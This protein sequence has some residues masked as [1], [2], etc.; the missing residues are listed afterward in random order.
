MAAAPI[1]SWTP[2]EPG[3]FAELAVRAL[4][5]CLDG[6]PPTRAGTTSGFVVGVRHDDGDGRLDLE[7]DADRATLALDPTLVPDHPWRDLWVL[8]IEHGEEALRLRVGDPP[9]AIA[10]RPDDPPGPLRRAGSFAKQTLG[11]V[12]PI[13]GV[14]DPVL[15]RDVAFHRYTRQTT[16]TAATA[17]G[18]P[19]WSQPTEPEHTPWWELDLGAG[20][21]LARVRVVVAR[22][23][24][25]ARVRVHAFGLH[26]PSGALPPRSLVSDTACEPSSE[27]PL[28]SVV[29]E[30]D[31][32]RRGVVARYLRI[33]LVAEEPV[34]LDVRA[35]ELLGSSLYE[36]TLLKTARTTFRLF[37]DRPLVLARGD[38]G[39][40]TATH[41]YGA[42]WTE[43][44][45]LARAL[46]A[47]LEPAPSRARVVLA[48]RG[49]PAWLIA[50][51]ACLLRAYV[52]V[53]IATDEPDERLAA[54]LTRVEPACV[55]AD[56]ADVERLRA[57]VPGA[58]LLVAVG[59]SVEGALEWT[60]LLAEGA[61]LAPIEDAARSEDDVHAIL[62]TSG[63]GGVPKGAMRTYA[64]F[65]DVI[66]SYSLGASPRHLSFQPLSHLSE[67]MFLPAVL[68]HGG[69]I[70][71]SRGPAHLL[72]ELRAFEPTGVGTVPRLFAS[73]HATYRRRLSA[74][75]AAAPDRTR[76]ELEGE[77]LAETRASLGRE[78]VAISI[79]SAPVSRELLAFVRHAFDDVWVSEGYG[80]TEVGTIA[81]DGR[82]AE[83]VEVELRP[84]GD[85]AD[86]AQEIWVRSP[87]VIAG[88]LGDGDA[89]TIDERGFFA[90]GDLGE[91]DA[92][93]RVRVVGRARNAI[94]L[95]AGEFVAVD[96]VEAV[97]G[98]AT[99]VDRVY[100]HAEPGGDGLAALVVPDAAA[101]ATALGVEPAP[102]EALCAHEDAPR[103]VLRALRAHGRAA[104]AAHELPSAA[105]L[106]AE[107]LRVEDGL[108]T[109]SGKLVRSA[110]ANRYGA[111][112]TALL[113]A[114]A[115]LEHDPLAAI[116]EDLEGRVR[117]IAASVLGRAVDLDE[118]LADAAIESLAAAELLAALS[119][120]LGREV[121]PAWLFG[122]AS[123]AALTERL[124]RFEHGFSAE[125]DEALRED[126]ARAPRVTPTS[127]L[128]A[129]RSRVLLTG[130]TGF[131][132]AH[133]VEAL[134]ARGLHV[135]ALVRAPDDAAAEARLRAALEGWRVPPVADAAL[136]AVAGDLDA[137]GLGLDEE[138]GFDAVVHAGARVSW[139]AGY[140]ALRGANVGGTIA[141][142]ERAA[143]RGAT[144]HHVSTISVAPPDADEDGFF[145]LDRVRASSTPY[146]LSKWVAESHVRRAAAAGLDVAVH[147]P[148]M[149]AA[150]STR[151][152]ANREDF[153]HRYLAAVI[154]LG[155]YVDDEVAILDMT[156]VDFVA[157]AIA[158]LVVAGPGAGRTHH[159]A[160][161]EGSLSYAALGRAV[162]AAGVTAA[163]VSH[164]RFLEALAA[165]EGSRLA[166]LASFIATPASLPMGPWPCA[167]TVAELEA[168]GV[169]RPRIDEAYVARV[170]AFLRQRR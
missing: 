98:G 10:R 49:G 153:V 105:L 23:P 148:A 81:V 111:A 118:P 133:L 57:L 155:V 8:V 5:A 143:A 63:S 125:I 22:P 170:V 149:I 61:R 86:G 162:S 150:H 37:R 21:Y 145:D 18:V 112:L 157:E 82:V 102:L 101:L 66:A 83:G 70:A 136:R 31:Q 11:L 124:A 96:R 19:R 47:R 12:H 52:T 38:D 109:A 54:I 29:L 62:F 139:L 43:A 80:S 51:L 97:L 16:W 17:D 88:Y 50:E 168:L 159:L 45:A 114:P 134:V 26:R 48:T 46:H 15:L 160:N 14:S 39:A 108:L 121:P 75:A 77:A 122:S 30:L 127:P 35:T 67:R 95:A 71:F 59:D 2:A 106:V 107:P 40:F 72:S 41:D 103:V 117:R 100:V 128:R 93:G 104:L 60:E 69:V 32:R 42:I 142:L 144:F 129:E 126:L 123:L 158:A 34:V 65:R 76:A 33:E 78:L 131:L 165:S 138:L 163:P 73:L 89:A 74:L 1:V 4:V 90:T 36:P 85:A 135:T 146:A 13:E 92:D 68:A 94:K 56:G 99:V 154:E 151:G 167:R 152:V 140:R 161:V 91:R 110:I 3:L 156:P 115:D 116:D 166:P 28:L 84:V 137:E 55:V 24:V 9:L 120:E 169:R 53:P 79:G 6:G 7:L 64:G 20:H 130:A 132:G 119:T 113:E 164:A 87:H 147:R 58:P 44:R 27:E 141:L 25:A